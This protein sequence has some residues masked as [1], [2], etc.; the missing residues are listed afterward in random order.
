V[1]YIENKTDIGLYFAAIQGQSNLTAAND[2]MSVFNGSAQ[3]VETAQSL[4]DASLAAAET[5]TT[6]LLLPV[7]GVVD[8]PFA[9]V[10]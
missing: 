7:I 10:V 9:E 8:N 2:V 3:S 6:E 1:L 4:A 5:G